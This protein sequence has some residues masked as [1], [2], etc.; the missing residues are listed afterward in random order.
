MLYAMCLA[1]GI[2][3]FIQLEGNL[4]GES[5]NIGGQ[6]TKKEPYL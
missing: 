2:R 5:P 1:T 4:R 3:F 6:I